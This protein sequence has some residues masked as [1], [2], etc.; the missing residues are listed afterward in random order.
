[1][2]NIYVMN[3]N[4]LVVE[5]VLHGGKERKS[6]TD[7]NPIVIQVVVHYLTHNKFG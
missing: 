2:K 6:V 5:R 4:R 7:I 3:L 1:M